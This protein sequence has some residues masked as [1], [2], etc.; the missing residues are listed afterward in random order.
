MEMAAIQ[1]LQRW[2]GLTVSEQESLARKIGGHL[3]ATFVFAELR[4]C[5]FMDEQRH[6]AIFAYHSDWPHEGGATVHFALLPGVE[7]TLGYDPARPFAPDAAQEASWRAFAQSWLG[8]PEADL[9]TYLRRVLTPLR[10]V[11][12]APFLLETSAHPLEQPIQLGEQFYTYRRPAP[13][14]RGTLE[15]VSAQGLRLPTPDEWEYACSAGARTVWRWGDHCPSIA[16]PSPRQAAPAW[17]LHLRPNAFGLQIA[18]YPTE[19]ELTTT[20]GRMRGGDGGTCL[21]TASIIQWLM[22]ASAVDMRWEEDPDAEIY[23]AHLRRAYS[24]DPALLFD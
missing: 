11:R 7:T 20:L 4:L 1:S 12:L 6:V 18:R 15:T 13:T 17:D 14:Y 10:R 19:W 3:P 21:Q 22:L 8:E 16:V 24:I 9:Q 5:T 2:D 23:A